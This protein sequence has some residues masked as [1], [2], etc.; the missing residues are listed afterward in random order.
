MSPS[1]KPLV[2]LRGEV[3]T[4][5]FSKEARIESGYLLRLLQNG[6]LLSMPQSRPMHSIGKKCHELRINDTKKTWRIV[7]RIDADAIIIADVF[8]KKTEQTPL[9]VIEVCKR[10]LND[11]D[12]I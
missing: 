7:Y 1:D 9:H 6:Q 3:Q 10:R 11:Y 8:E 2:W 12:A 4:P 5:P